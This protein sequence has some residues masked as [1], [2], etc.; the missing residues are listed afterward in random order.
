MD[1][2]NKRSTW[3]FEIPEEGTGEDPVAARRDRVDVSP[4]GTEGCLWWD[5]DFSYCDPDEPS[6]QVEQ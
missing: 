4:M 5:W 3:L 6:E 2:S 1:S